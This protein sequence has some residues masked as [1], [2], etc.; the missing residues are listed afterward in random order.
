MSAPSDRDDD[1]TLEDLTFLDQHGAGAY[2]AAR[3]CGFPSVAALEKWAARHGHN[4]LWRSLRTRDPRGLREQK[5][6][7]GPRTRTLEGAA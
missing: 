2:E 6:N 4:D 7:R 3:R 5:R 1:A